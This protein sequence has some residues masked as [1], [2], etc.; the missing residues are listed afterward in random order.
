MLQHDRNRVYALQLQLQELERAH[1]QSVANLCAE[2]VNLESY[3]YH[4]EPVTQ[5]KASKAKKKDY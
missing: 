5:T 2:R 1:P 4:A 3:Y